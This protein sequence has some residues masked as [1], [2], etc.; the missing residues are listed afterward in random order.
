[1]KLKQLEARVSQIER[2]GNGGDAIGRKPF[3]AEVAIRAQTYSPCG[4]LVGNLPD[5]RLELTSLDGDT[6]IANTELE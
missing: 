1:M 6:E 2:D 5:A 3:I 4:E